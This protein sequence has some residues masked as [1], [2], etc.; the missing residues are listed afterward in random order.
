MLKRSGHPPSTA[1]EEPRPVKIA[2]VASKASTRKS[3]QVI[4]ADAFR[5]DANAALRRVKTSRRHVVIA[6]R[7][8]PTAVLISAAAFQHAERERALLVSLLRGDREIA[9]GR[10]H[11][12]ADVA[13]EAAALLRNA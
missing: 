1:L 2:S 3:R 7:G 4:Q 12:L 5:R 13:A 9:S 10:G 6:E 11:D 8:R